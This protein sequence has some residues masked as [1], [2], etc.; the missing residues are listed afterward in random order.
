[1]ATRTWLSSRAPAAQAEP[2]LRQMPSSSRRTRERWWSTPSSVRA[3]I[4]GRRSDGSVGPSTRTPSVLARPLTSCLRSASTCDVLASSLSHAS[5]SAAAMPAAPATFDVPARRPRSCAPPRTSDAGSTRCEHTSAPIP[6]GPWNLWAER[7]SRSKPSRVKSMGR[8]PVAWT[9]SVWKRA[10]RL[11]AMRQTSRA[12][13][14][15]PTSL[16]ANMRETRQVSG[17]MA[18]LTSATLTRPLASGLTSVTSKFPP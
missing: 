17:R 5:S 11:R 10:P 14:T 3:T 15:A 18:A 12:G 2:A 4:P 8:W 1:M 9:A 13:C 6:R 7:V 16:F